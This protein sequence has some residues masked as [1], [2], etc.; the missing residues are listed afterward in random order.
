MINNTGESN[1]LRGHYSNNNLGRSPRRRRR[2]VGAER[3][4]RVSGHDLPR[5]SIQS[6]PESPK[7]RRMR[8]RRLPDLRP[9]P[10]GVRGPT[11]I[12]KK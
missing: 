5:F 2:V 7:H 8:P 1:P 4:S 10:E 12:R 6:S 11:C 3:G 9:I